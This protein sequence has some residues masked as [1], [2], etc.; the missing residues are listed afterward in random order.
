MRG[1]VILSVA[2]RLLLALAASTGTAHSCSPQAG[3]SWKCKDDDDD[4]DDDDDSVLASAPFQSLSPSKPNA[5]HLTSPHLM[6]RCAVWACARTR[7]PTAA[8]TT[9]VPPVTTTPP[10]AGATW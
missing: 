1:S 2:S 5:P 7:G 9:T 3:L 8:K 4:D 6:P 10:P